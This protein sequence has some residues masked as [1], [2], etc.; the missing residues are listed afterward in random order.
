MIS[1]TST[2][3]S[4]G[5]NNVA[6]VTG[7]GSTWTTSSFGVG[8][9]GSYNQAI[10][11]KGG[12]LLSS[13]GY[14]GANFAGSALGRGNSVVVTDTN[15]AWLMGGNLGIGNS[16]SFNPL[17]ITNGGLVQSAS[18]TSFLIANINLYIELKVSSFIFL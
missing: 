9:N 7:A 1:V 16:D 4:S 13:S 8:G 14:I 18:G 11:S 17:I 6:T 10:I 15:S 3:G 5:S 12:N 2:V